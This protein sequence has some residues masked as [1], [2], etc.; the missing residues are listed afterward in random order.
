MNFLQQAME[1]EIKRSLLEVY[2]HIKNLKEDHPFIITHLNLIPTSDE[3][4][5]IQTEYTNTKNKY[6]R[7]TGDTLFFVDGEEIKEKMP[8]TN[9]SEFL[10]HNMVK[11]KNKRI[12]HLRRV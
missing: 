8:I 3:D 4:V 9:F 6:F 1:E 12:Q 2:N 11:D 10:N 5:I 7:K